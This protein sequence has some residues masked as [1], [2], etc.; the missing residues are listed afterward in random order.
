MNYAGIGARATPP[1]IID[2]MRE[3]GI[4]FAKK[5]YTLHTGAA[6]GADQAFAEG[7]IYGGGMVR[8]FL[9]WPTYEQEWISGLNK[10]AEIVVLRDS[11][12]MAHLSVAELHPT[13]A[14]LSQGVRKL[15]ARNFL[16]LQDIGFVTCWTPNG[17]EA[18]GT[19][20]GIRIAE[21]M[22]TKIW[23]LGIPKVYEGMGER[24]ELTKLENREDYYGT[25]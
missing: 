20:Q 22:D 4:A 21:R 13:F 14:T 23:N 25:T 7:A 6:Q 11:D 8:L 3:L 16:I 9:P 15:H 24:L 10:Q 2:M 19:G 5:G 17:V 1:H 12:R 18:G